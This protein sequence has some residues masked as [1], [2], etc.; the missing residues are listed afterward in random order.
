MQALPPH[1][2]SRDGYEITAISCPD[3]PGVLE[4]RAESNHLRFRCRIGHVYSLS[5]VV[6]GKE[7]RLDDLLWSL[8]TAF[9]ELAN[10]LEEA[11]VKGLAEESRQPFAERAASIRQYQTTLRGMLDSNLPVVVANDVAPA[12]E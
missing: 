6:Q 10:I 7:R 3:C 8:L 12:T 5:E 4:V 9:D 11:V 1:P 2:E